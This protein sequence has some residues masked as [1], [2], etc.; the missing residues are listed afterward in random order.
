MGL[1]D[2]SEKLFYRVLTSDIERFMPIIYTPTVGLACQLYGL[3]FTRPR[4][5]IFYLNAIKKY[6]LRCGSAYLPQSVN[7]FFSLFPPSESFI[8]HVFS[9]FP[10]PFVW[11]SCFFNCWLW[12]ITISMVQSAFSQK[13][14]QREL[15]KFRLPPI[16][17]HW[18]IYKCLLAAIMRNK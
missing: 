16:T 13:D 7:V 2:R 11:A 17:S 9:F 1:Q 18:L 14:K 12:G 8:R 5:D 3:I 10:Q 6:I 15:P 4:W